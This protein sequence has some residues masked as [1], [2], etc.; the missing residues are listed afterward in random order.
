MC[1]LGLFDTSGSPHPKAPANWLCF[2]R[3]LLRSSPG[4]TGWRASRRLL[5]IGFVSHNGSPT[6][7]GDNGLL[8]VKAAKAT[9]AR[10]IG[11]VLYGGFPARPNWVCFARLLLDVHYLPFQLSAPRRHGRA[12]PIRF[13]ACDHNSL[14]RWLYIIPT[15]ALG[16][17]QDSVPRRNF[18]P[19]PRVDGINPCQRRSWVIR[20]RTVGGLWPVPFGTQK[21]ILAKE[22][23][24]SGPSGYMAVVLCGAPARSSAMDCVYRL[25]DF[26]Q[27]SWGS[28]YDL[29]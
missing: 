27:S 20:A 13:T 21:S 5:P 18:F 11:F 4:G 12:L 23:G 14:L 15:L 2:A 17:K 9:P 28:C 6:Q 26:Q 3:C 10:P 8:A 25:A 22:Q 29:W 1:Q 19:G 7:K 16:V 24:F